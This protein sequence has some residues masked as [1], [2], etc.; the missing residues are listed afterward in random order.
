MTYS[1]AWSKRIQ[2]ELLDHANEALPNECCGYITG[3]SGVCKT[4]HKMTNADP[5]PTYFEFDPKEQFQVIKA[6]RAVGEV[7]VVV[8]HSH[9]NSPARLSAKDLELL[10]D[11]DMTYA[12]ISIQDSGS[13]IKAYRIIDGTIYDVMIDIIKED[14]YVN[15]C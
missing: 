12:I 3:R 14:E 4:L 2:D 5:S 10:T 11:P 1:I 8:Y 6:A 7:P 9:P 15:E 13:D